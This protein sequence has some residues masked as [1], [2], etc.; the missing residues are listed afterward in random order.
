MADS[1]TVYVPLAHP[2][3]LRRVLLVVQSFGGRPKQFLPLDKRLVL[4]VDFPTFQVAQE[5]TAICTG[6]ICINDPLS[7][8]T[9]NLQQLFKNCD[10][11]QPQP[12]R[13]AAAAS[14]ALNLTPTPASTARQPPFAGASTPH[15]TVP[16]QPATPTR[17]S[18]SQGHS[19]LQAQSTANEKP[20]DPDRERIKAQMREK[21]RQ[22][23]E[24]ERQEQK[25]DQPWLTQNQR[26]RFRSGSM[27]EHDQQAA[28]PPSD[29]PQSGPAFNTRSHAKAQDVAKA[30]ARDATAG[31]AAMARQME[32]QVQGELPERAKPV[33]LKKEKRVFSITMPEEKRAT[34]YDAHFVSTITMET[35]RKIE[36]RI[37]R[38][39]LQSDCNV[40]AIATGPNFDTGTIFQTASRKW[41]DLR[42][43]LSTAPTTRHQGTSYKTVQTPQG[44]LVMAIHIPEATDVGI[45]YDAVLNAAHTKQYHSI[46]M[47]MFRG[48]TDVQ[49]KFAL[50]AFLRSLQ[51]FLESTPFS[52][53]AIIE[54]CVYKPSDALYREIELALQEFASLHHNPV[55]DQLAR[56]TPKPQQPHLAQPQQRHADAAHT[57]QSEP[58]KK[59]RTVLAT[60]AHVLAKPTVRF[61]SGDLGRNDP[62]TVLVT[63]VSASE[64]SEGVWESRG[65]CKLAT[66]QNLLCVQSQSYSSFYLGSIWNDLI[67]SACVLAQ[68]I[69]R[70]RIV[71]I[72]LASK[73]KDFA[74]RH[75]KVDVV[76]EASVFMRALDMVR[77]ETVGFDIDF[78]IGGADISQITAA[79][80][81]NYDWKPLDLAV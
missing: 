71:F 52:Q 1:N 47:P 63:N 18:I 7:C 40:L 26:G 56:S 75:P 48:I 5:F 6:S 24:K 2:G 41:Y 73:A 31:D 65:I 23:E 25:V 20:H 79:L 70:Q 77:R 58:P 76:E 80:K 51:S 19:P 46:A 49:K 59:P 81:Y 44:P 74:T 3:T 33:P 67:K 35:G 21:Q 27:R 28:A 22:K 12:Q 37:K 69:K 4:P 13:A 11:P 60:Y 32:R 8:P 10:V 42:K 30:A 45:G 53:I 17:S 50:K 72:P 55:E 43:R 9:L 14:A 62:N 29:V 78:Y 64:L 66:W 61:I 68:H 54:A 39:L 36:L 57:Q 34:Y 16:V 38:D 15:V